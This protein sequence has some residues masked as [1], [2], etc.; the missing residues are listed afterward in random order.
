MNS[1][2]DYF[3]INEFTQNYDAGYLSTYLSKGIGGKYKMVIWDFNSACNNYQDDITGIGFQTQNTP[4]QKMLTRDEDYDRRII[5]RYRMW[6]ESFLSEA[7]LMTI[8]T[9]SPP[10]W[11]R[12]LTGILMSGAIRLRNIS[13]WSRNPAIRTASRTR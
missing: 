2:V 1:F 6:R 9:P 7:Y 10:T 4:W 3:I 13:P 12:P 11:A 5:Q 8:S